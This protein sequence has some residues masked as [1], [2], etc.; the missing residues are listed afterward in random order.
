MRLFSFIFF[1]FV[2]GF[3]V[4]CFESS[5]SDANMAASIIN[6]SCFVLG[7][8]EK[9]ECDFSDFIKIK[10]DIFRESILDN[11]IECRIEKLKSHSKKMYLYA[12]LSDKLKALD[13][14]RSKSYLFKS[15]FFAYEKFSYEDELYCL[16]TL[17]LWLNQSDENKVMYALILIS[18]L[19]FSEEKVFSLYRVFSIRENL[20]WFR[21]KYGRDF[22]NPSI[23][24]VLPVYYR[25]YDIIDIKNIKTD[26]L[27]E[28]FKYA[29]LPFYT[30]WGVS[31]FERYNYPIIAYAFYLGG[32]F[33]RYSEFRE[34]SVSQQQ[35][36]AMGKNYFK[37][38]AYA[39]KIFCLAGDFDYAVKLLD[40]LPTS[41]KKNRVLKVMARYF[42]KSKIGLSIAIKSGL[43]N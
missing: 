1:I 30:T 34:K 42:A 40:T 2:F 10:R 18:K 23:K 11:S 14:I 22:S 5:D 4:K 27:M 15:Y 25:G 6:E 26:V 31:E 8:G 29:A 24:A 12:L 35:L 17:D 33:L 32:D 37:Y 9:S 43:Y 19:P 36:N 39:S 16:D 41:R 20:E 3:F 28:R 38:V 7:V 21:T 13:S